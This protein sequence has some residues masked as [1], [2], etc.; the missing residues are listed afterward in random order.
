MPLVDP[1]RYVYSLGHVREARKGPHSVR[2]AAA[3]GVTVGS[4]GG[5]LATLAAFIG[6]PSV[7]AARAEYPEVGHDQCQIGALSQRND[8]VDSGRIL[9]GDGS[10]AD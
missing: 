8:V 6:M 2:P 9:G 3:L 5:D 10:V 7:V 1:G 4:G